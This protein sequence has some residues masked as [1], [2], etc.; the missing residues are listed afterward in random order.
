MELNKRHFIKLVGGGIVVSA[1]ASAGFLTTRTPRKALGP[2]E[3]AGQYSDP[4]MQALSYAI[5]APNPHN[6]QPWEVELVGENKIRIYRDKNKNLP[7]TDPFERQLTIGM[8]CF[9]ELL[10]I[11][12][13]ELGYLLKINYFLNGKNEKNEFVADV[14][15]KPSKSI[16]K[17][18]LFSS[19]ID[20][21]SSKEP[22]EKTPLSSNQINRLNKFG[23]VI[24]KKEEVETLKKITWDAF[25]VEY[26]TPKTLK[27]SV[28]LMRF[29]KN[30]IN[31]SPDGIDIGGGFLEAM[32]LLGIINSKT[33]LDPNSSAYS[34]GLDIYE[35]MLSATPNYII[36]KTKNNKRIDQLL[37]GRQWARLN[38]TTT[39]MG[40]ALHPVS[41]A[42]Q[43]YK[44]MKPNY[45][46]IHN[47]FSSQGQVIQMLGRLGT[48]MEIPPSPRWS[49]ENK[50][51]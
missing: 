15:F 26:K 29:G 18:V 22:F 34:Q 4:R 47:E 21:R 2:W 14:L 27:E 28:D 31:S 16:K 13:N 51:I 10:N 35:K 37:I 43:E 9:I 3:K 45:E 49:I 33:L 6:R 5:L 42:L 32:N 46:K 1:L 50:I 24:H 20:R 19:I 11:A 12:A 38:L 7:E 44:E 8:G 40:L 25:V 39:K 36:L 48:S 30:E 41:Q 23:K 17:D